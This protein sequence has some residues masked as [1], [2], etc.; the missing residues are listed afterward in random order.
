MMKSCACAALARGDDLV[1]GRARLAEG[2]VVANGAVEQE[3]VLADIGD[4]PAQRV[5]RHMRDILAVDQDARRVRRRRSAECRLRMVDLPPPD[6][7]TSAVILPGSATKDMPRS[8]GS[9]LP[10]GEM[11]VLE[12]DP[13]RCDQQR[14]AC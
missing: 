7:P 14:A 3:H 5:A 4:L 1:V 9:S 12:L 10:I 11:H 8:T 2:D 6:G 13:R